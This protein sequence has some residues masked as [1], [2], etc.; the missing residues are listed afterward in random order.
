M[1][2][3]AEFPLAGSIH[4]NRPHTQVVVE[5]VAV[6][7]QETQSFHYLMQSPGDLQVPSST[8]ICLSLQV[9]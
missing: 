7:H 8:F 1:V 4:E 5:Q 3:A 9:D 6:V 2:E